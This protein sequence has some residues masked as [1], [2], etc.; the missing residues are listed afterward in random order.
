MAEHHLRFCPS[1]ASL[2]SLYSQPWSGR[3]RGKRLRDGPGLS[4]SRHSENGKEGTFWR[5]MKMVILKRMWRVGEGESPGSHPPFCLGPADGV[6]I[7]WDR[8]AR[9]SG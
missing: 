7:G 9:Q 4:Q 6:A 8:R 3:D 5:A 2:P 1:G